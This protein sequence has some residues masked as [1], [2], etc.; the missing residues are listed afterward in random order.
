VRT[1]IALAAIVGVVTECVLAGVLRGNFASLSTYSIQSNL[2][3]AV[4]FTFSAVQILRGLTPWKSLTIIERSAR[5]WV[6]VTGLGFHFLVS[7]NWHP[8]GIQGMANLLL[9][10]VV[11]IGAFAAWLLCEQKGCYRVREFW[12]WASYPLLGAADT[13][14]VKPDKRYRAIRHT[15]IWYHFHQAQ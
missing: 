11:P 10:Y 1:F 13:E 6:Y 5:L 8:R 14:D 9:H 7:S 4:V 12:V 3:I 2:I 15:D